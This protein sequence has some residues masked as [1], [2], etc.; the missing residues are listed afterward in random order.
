M[1]VVFAWKG[2]DVLTTSE[3]PLEDLIARARAGDQDALGRLLEGYRHYLRLLAHAGLGRQ[4][5]PRLDPSDLVQE[6]LLEANRDFQQFYGKTSGEVGAWLRQIL[7]RN[8]ADQVKRHQSQKRDVGREEPLARLLDD[9]PQALAAP[10]STPSAQAVRHEQADRL[11]LALADLPPDYREVVM[12][13]HVQ[14]QAFE[15]IAA[16]MGRSPGAVRMLWVRAL[17]QL[18]ALVETGDETA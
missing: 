13:R 8:L 12:L 6:T 15:T 2:R 14:G 1:C 11:N 10:N 18:G 4:L 9:S 5:R 17:E 7:A 3:Q 16:Q